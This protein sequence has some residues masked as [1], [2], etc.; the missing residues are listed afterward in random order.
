M[1]AEYSV[2]EE[3]HAILQGDGGIS[4]KIA[5]DD[6]RDMPFTSTCSQGFLGQDFRSVF[7]IPKLTQLLKYVRLIIVYYQRSNFI[8]QRL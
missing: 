4:E 5:D 7:T 3:M 1:S 2:G 8:Q 6:G